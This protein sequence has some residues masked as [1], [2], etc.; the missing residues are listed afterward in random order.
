MKLIEIIGMNESL[1]RGEEHTTI[2]HQN[3]KIFDSFVFV[4]YYHIPTCAC[5]HLMLVKFKNSAQMTPLKEGYSA[6]GLSFDD[7][8][9]L[10]R[11]HMIKGSTGKINLL[12]NLW[13]DP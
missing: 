2:S 9:S 7:M 6:F 13:F 1:A 11:Q 4:T 8:V 12:Y 3:T 10:G 5:K